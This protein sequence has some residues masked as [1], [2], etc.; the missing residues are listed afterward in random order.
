MIVPTGQ[1][2][3]ELLAA[4]RR[5]S[6]VTIG[7]MG[8]P[9]YPTPDEIMSDPPTHKPSVIAFLKQWKRSTWRAAKESGSE[10]IK[11]EALATMIRGIAEIYRRP[12]EVGYNSELGSACY[13]PMQHK[14][15]LNKRLSI[16]TALHELAHHLFGTS[17]T[18]ACRWSVHLF[19]KTFPRAFS[20]LEWRGHLLVKRNNLTEQPCST[21]T[22]GEATTLPPTNTITAAGSSA[23]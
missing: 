1:E 7:S 20:R 22:S 6:N 14:V 4:M 21:L 19:K 13:V 18:K 17:E 2:M 11:Y 23:S 12:V 8:H 15:V 5:S 10:M 16:I 9:G 3:N